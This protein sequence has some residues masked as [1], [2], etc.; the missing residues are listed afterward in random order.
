MWLAC[1]GPWLDSLLS[2]RQIRFERKPSCILSKHHS[3]QGVALQLDELN[4]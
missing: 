4:M 1:C 3:N 2:W